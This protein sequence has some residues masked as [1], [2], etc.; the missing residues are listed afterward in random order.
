MTEAQL[1]GICIALS[2]LVQFVAMFAV[3]R[4]RAKTK[5]NAPAVTG[6]PLLER[7]VRAQANTV[8]QALIFYP[9]IW[10]CATNFSLLVAGILGL[11]WVAARFWYVF[12]YIHS[13]GARSMP[14]L[15]GLLA[16][17][18]LFALGSYGMFA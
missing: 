12:A 11:L 15:F 8:E 13:S 18:L 17:F 3:G 7:A 16:T 1:L 4:A 2:V 14:F 5:I 9:A 6:D 10:L